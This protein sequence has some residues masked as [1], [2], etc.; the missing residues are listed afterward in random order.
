MA[1]RLFTIQ[2][3]ATR[4]TPE[5]VEPSLDE[6]MDDIA[7]AIFERQHMAPQCEAAE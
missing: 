3:L 2:R 7:V 1:D 6:E 5:Y 4:T